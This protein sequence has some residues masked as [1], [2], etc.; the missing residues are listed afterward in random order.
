[1][2]FSLKIQEFVRYDHQEFAQLSL[3]Y[4]GAADELNFRRPAAL[5]KARWMAKVICSLKI[6]LCKSKIAELP[7]GK[8]TTRHQV[9]KICAFVTFITHVYSIW[10][11][12][13]NTTVDAAW[14]DLELYKRLLQ[15]RVVDKKIAQSAIIAFDCHLWYLT[16]EMVLL[17]LFSNR[18][19]LSEQQALADALNAVKQLRDLQAPLN[20]LGL[21]GAN[22]RNSLP[23]KSMLQ[24]DCATLFEKTRG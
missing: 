15:Y 9:P 3:V 19:P 11:I 16:A 10:L 22:H 6:A 1:M 23:Q 2:L 18:V 17:A 20:R 4:L 7:P 8:I 24:Q 21:D 12:T 13:C 5:H 14:N